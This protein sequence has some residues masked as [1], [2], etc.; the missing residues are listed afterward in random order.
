MDSLDFLILILNLCTLWI[1]LDLRIFIKSNGVYSSL[2]WI[3]VG[4]S[5]PSRRMWWLL[6]TLKYK[7]NNRQIGKAELSCMLLRFLMIDKPNNV[8]DKMT[9]GFG[10]N[11]QIF[12][13]HLPRLHSIS[14]TQATPVWANSHVPFISFW[15]FQV[16][17]YIYKKPFVPFFRCAGPDVSKT[18]W[19]HG[20]LLFPLWRL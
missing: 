12:G 13:R 6:L 4:I 7:D 19:S 5:R 11:H 2:F 16:E 9:S 18:W 20:S 8:S 10:W 3:N 15:C 17:Y 1:N 14:S